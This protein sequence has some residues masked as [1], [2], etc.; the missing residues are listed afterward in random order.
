MNLQIL[1]GCTGTDLGLPTALTYLG[2]PTA[3]TDPDRAILNY[4]IT[5]MSFLHCIGVC[6][7][8]RNVAQV[9]QRLF[10][11]DFNSVSNNDFEDFL[12]KPFNKL[13]L[14]QPLPRLS[15]PEV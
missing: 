8:F 14:T 13:L 5:G 15:F 7:S 2:I 12:A 9:F 3:R 1:N 4:I 11:V 6:S 10:S